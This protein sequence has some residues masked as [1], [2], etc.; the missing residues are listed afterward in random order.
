MAAA[1]RILTL[2][3]LMW[4][5]LG[6][7]EPVAAHGDMSA[8]HQLAGAMHDSDEPGDTPEAPEPGGH[9][10]CP[11]APDLPPLGDAVGV[12]PVA[13]APFADRCG[14]LASLSRA[15]PLQPPAA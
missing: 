13:A 2:I 10:H 1:L 14:P 4:C 15:P 8:Q 6:V 7:G 12:R 11:V 9:H 3:C 5:A